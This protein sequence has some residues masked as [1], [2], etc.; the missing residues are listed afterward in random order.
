MTT[1]TYTLQQTF[2][3]VAVHLLE[4]HARAK[5]IRGENT[6]IV[7][8]TSRKCAAGCLIP[9]GR[10]NPAFEDKVVKAIVGIHF[11]E[12]MGGSWFGHN[13]AFVAKLQHLHDYVAP[14]RWARKLR[15]LA[16]TYH[17]ST[18]AIR[19]KNEQDFN[20]TQSAHTRTIPGR[21]AWI[22]FLLLSTHLR[23]P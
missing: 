5:N 7:P 1:E 15:L 10:Y 11:A 22:S 14:S 13:T 19:G 9:D 16:R 6:Y 4:Q 2:D 18:T 23:L 8:Q 3:I 12:E 20:Q 21:N 17:L